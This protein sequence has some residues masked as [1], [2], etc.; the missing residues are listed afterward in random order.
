MRQ[1]CSEP[2]KTCARLEPGK[3]ELVEN[4]H[5]QPAES[6]EQH[7][8]MK[9]RHAG[10]RGGEEQEV[11]RD[12]EDHGHIGRRIMIGKRCRMEPGA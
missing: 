9:Q 8:A 12:I 1:V 11:E 4:Q 2:R 6:N 7:M 10:Q 3:A 5:Q